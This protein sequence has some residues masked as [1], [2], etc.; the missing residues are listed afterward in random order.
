MMCVYVETDSLSQ[1]QIL[2]EAIGKGMDPT[3]L[4]PAMSN[5]RVDLA[6]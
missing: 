5:K 6:L 1:I 4:L 2:D 3:I